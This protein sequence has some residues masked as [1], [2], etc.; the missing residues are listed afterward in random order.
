M[1]GEI[2]ARVFRDVAKRGV[3]SLQCPGAGRAGFVLKIGCSLARASQSCNF[4][5][6]K[7]SWKPWRGQENAY[8]GV[9]RSSWGHNEERNTCPLWA[10]ETHG[11]AESSR[12]PWALA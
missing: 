1:R 10:T 12:L 9:T 11:W 3:G 4:P 5:S 2:K 8:D 7:L 6:L